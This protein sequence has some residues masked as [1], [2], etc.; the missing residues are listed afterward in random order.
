MQEFTAPIT[1]NYKLEVWG[2][3]GGNSYESR[4][5]VVSYTNTV[6]GGKGG[7]CSGEI[8]LSSNSGFYIYVGQSGEGMIERTFNGGG[9][10]SNKHNSRSGG[11]ATDIRL[12]NGIWS[13]FNSLKSRIIMKGVM[14]EMQ[15]DYRGR[16]D[17]IL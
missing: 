16:T 6:Y 15:V 13:N 4:S 11:G 3:S 5:S 17:L 2:A 14:E 10:G 8:T 1:G 12:I 7:Y 9:I